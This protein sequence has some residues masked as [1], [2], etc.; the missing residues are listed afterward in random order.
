M[1]RT[2]VER[3]WRV[4][5]SGVVTPS[6]VGVAMLKLRYP[7]PPLPNPAMLG[8]F[9]MYSDVSSSRPIRVTVSTLREWMTLV[10]L[11][12]CS[13][14]FAR[15]M[16]VSTSATRTNGTNGIICSWSTNRCPASVSPKSSSVSPGPRP[17]G[18][19]PRPR[20]FLADQTFVHDELALVVARRHEARLRQG[21]DL[22]AVQPH[23]VVA[24]HRL[25]QLV[26]DGGDREHLLLADAQQV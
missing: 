13:D 23:R 7:S 3:R 4:N 22:L 10:C 25:Q 17:A 6:P 9:W 24:R 16:A 20:R 11:K 12:P 8:P 21:L 14:F 26:E 15:A 5:V 18:R 2:V 1:L 19:S